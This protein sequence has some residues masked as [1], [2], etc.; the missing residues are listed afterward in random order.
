MTWC[1]GFTLK[2]FKK[3]GDTKCNKTGKIL[4][5]VE[6]GNG[7]SLYDSN[8]DIFHNKKLFKTFKITL[9]HSIHTS[10]SSHLSIKITHISNFFSLVGKLL[11][12][13]LILRGWFLKKKIHILPSQNFDSSSRTLV[14]PEFTSALPFTFCKVKQDLPWRCLGKLSICRDFYVVFKF[15]YSISPT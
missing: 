3:L 1:L 2:Y 13:A 6:A 8:F 9:T 5:T 10:S 4:I 15:S 11:I 7:G 12:L 14:S